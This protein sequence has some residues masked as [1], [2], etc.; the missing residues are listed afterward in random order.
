MRNLLLGTANMTVCMARCGVVRY[1]MQDSKKTK[2][3]NNMAAIL[4]V[5]TID[6]NEKLKKKYQHGRAAMTQ[7]ATK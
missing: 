6:V 1:G 7:R 5:S 2:N 4:V 3:N